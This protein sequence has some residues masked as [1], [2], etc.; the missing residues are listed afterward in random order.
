MIFEIYFPK[1]FLYCILFLLL[2]GI[3]S[4]INIVNSEKYFDVFLVFKKLKLPEL[5]NM[6]WSPFEKILFP[7]KK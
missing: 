3:V 6:I 1:L 5:F 2:G 7:I 4:A